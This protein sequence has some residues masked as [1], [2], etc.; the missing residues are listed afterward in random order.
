MSTAGGTAD[1]V[2]LAELVGSRAEAHAATE[3]ARLSKSRRGQVAKGE[4]SALLA[5]PDLGL[6]FRRTGLDA[7]LPGLKLL[8]DPDLAAEAAAEATGAFERSFSP[9]IPPTS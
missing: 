4:A 8:H 5:D 7:E 1:T 6:V 3:T 9:P 2:V